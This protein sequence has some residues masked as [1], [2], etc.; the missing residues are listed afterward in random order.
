MSE[1]NEDVMVKRSRD[2]DR[3]F[4]GVRR[5][6]WG[7]WVSEIREPGKK[8][9]IWLGSYDSPEMA[10]RA[11]DS[12]AFVLKGKSAVNFP[13]LIDTLPRPR[14]LD[15]RD[16]QSAAAQA[17]AA[18]STSNVM[19][20]NSSNISE[21]N[22]SRGESSMD[23]KN[24]HSGLLVIDSEANLSSKGREPY[25]FN[26]P[27]VVMDEELLF[28]WPNLVMHMAEA[29]LLT[30]PRLDEEVLIDHDADYDN[31]EAAQGFLWGHF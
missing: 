16:I 19:E 4:R 17:A 14:S 2:E 26:D 9:R 20:S 11:Y 3:K 30:P 8:R 15:P 28:D 12:A 24:R 7:K 29:L 27:L 10:A 6:R 18:A 23:A 5:R 1:I 13:H 31:I 22:I 21:S 25:N